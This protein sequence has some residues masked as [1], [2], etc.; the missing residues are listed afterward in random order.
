MIV[1]QTTTE[2]S[3]ERIR[4]FGSQSRHCRKRNRKLHCGYWVRRIFCELAILRDDYQWKIKVRHKFLCVDTKLSF[5]LLGYDFYRKNKVNI[6]TSAN[7]LL[8]Q[9]VPI[10]THTHKS[11]QTVG[12]ILTAN[13]I[14]EPYSENILEEQTEVQEAQLM[15]E[16]SCNLK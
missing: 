1:N 15:R 10:I 6:L 4:N 5:A 12:V 14:I 9:N 8:S 2:W 7:C 11:R 13:D 3:I 16:D